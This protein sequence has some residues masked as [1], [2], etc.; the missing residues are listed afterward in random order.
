MPDDVAWDD[1]ETEDIGD[2]FSASCPSVPGYVATGMSD[3]EARRAYLASLQRHRDE[4][5]ESGG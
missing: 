5:S 1:I 3:E 4:P 2:N